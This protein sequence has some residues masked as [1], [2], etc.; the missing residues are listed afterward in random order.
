MYFY[1]DAMSL[2][3][4][5]KSTGGLLALVQASDPP[6]ALEAY[7]KMRGHFSFAGLAYACGLAFADAEKAFGI[8]K[9]GTT[10]TQP[11]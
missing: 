4:V 10:Q 2:F 11:C 7:A 1:R 8:E 9:V 3:R 6:S 5:T